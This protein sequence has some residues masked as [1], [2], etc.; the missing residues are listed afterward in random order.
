MSPEKIDLGALARYLVEQLE[1]VAAAK[2]VSLRIESDEAVFV[3][4]DREWIE[5]AILNLM[6]NAVKYTQEGGIVTLVASNHAS[7]RM[8]EIRD[9]G[10][11]MKPDTLP[12]VRSEPGKGSS[13]TIHFPPAINR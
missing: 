11:G 8:L 12:H 2:Q 7:E 6:D 4:A 3:E 9:T 5:T 13:F 1:T 10:I